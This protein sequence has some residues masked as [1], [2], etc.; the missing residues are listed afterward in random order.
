MY[1]CECALT[2]TPVDATPKRN[3]I[4]LVDL[5]RASP[6]SHQ[7]AAGLLDRTPVVAPGPYT[8]SPAGNKPLEQHE[9]DVLGAHLG[10]L[11]VVEVVLEV[12]IPNTEFE[13]F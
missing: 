6:P 5:L 4:R 1:T 10:A 3:R 13:V 9:P 12:P 7:A 2:P 11:P 8:P